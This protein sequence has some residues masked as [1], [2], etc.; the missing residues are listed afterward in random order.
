MRVA[1]PPRMAGWLARC[2]PQLFPTLALWQRHFSWPAWG[3]LAF[4]LAAAALHWQVLPRLLREQARLQARALVLAA[5]AAED[6]RAQ[7]PEPLLIHEL[8]SARQRGRD[9]E[10]LVSASQRNGVQLDR[11]DYAV[12][13]ATSDGVSR[14]EATLPLVGTYG[15]LRRYVA[16]VLNQ[17]PHSALESLQIERPS[18]Q[19]PQLQATARLALFYREAT[20]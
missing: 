9:L 15:E 20:P 1:L 18:T 13:A 19:S 7:A 16:D 3:A 17:L 2:R 14:V 4:L 8:P 11:A 6:P 5:P 12:G 10:Y